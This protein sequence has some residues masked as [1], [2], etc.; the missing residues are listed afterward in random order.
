M[1]SKAFSSYSLVVCKCCISSK[2]GCNC[3]I[4]GFINDL[5]LL[6]LWF[7]ECVVNSFSVL[8]DD[9]KDDDEADEL[10]AIYTHTHTFIY[11]I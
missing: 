5:L 4:D 11:N 10:N 2:D 7:E 3:K 6:L 9:D 8:D 1:F